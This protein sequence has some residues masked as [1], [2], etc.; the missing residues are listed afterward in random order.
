MTAKMASK[1]TTFSC[2][3]QRAQHSDNF[4]MS[5]LVL[6]LVTTCIGTTVFT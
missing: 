3:S 2:V 1:S 5:V 4:P 6:V